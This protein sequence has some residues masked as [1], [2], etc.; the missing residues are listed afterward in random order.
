[1]GKSKP[2]QT[3]ISRQGKKCDPATVIVIEKPATRKRIGQKSR[4][5]ETIR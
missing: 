3:A 2:K 5:P 4:D 1:L